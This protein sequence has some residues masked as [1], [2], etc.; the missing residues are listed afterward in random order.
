MALIGQDLMK[1]EVDYRDQVDRRRDGQ[2]SDVAVAKLGPGG[3]SCISTHR[4][5][6]E[7]SC[8]KHPIFAH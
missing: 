6:R 1:A 3:K 4:Y 2:G 8:V 7:A 5:S